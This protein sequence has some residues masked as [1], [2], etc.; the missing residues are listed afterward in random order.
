MD[1][2]AVVTR[3]VEVI[4]NTGQLVKV[5]TSD[6]NAMFMPRQPRCVNNLV[7]PLML[8]DDVF[9][10]VSNRFECMRRHM[11]EYGFMDTADMSGFIKVVRKN[12][13]TIGDEDST[14]ERELDD[15]NGQGDLLP[16]EERCLYER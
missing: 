5:T 2:K 6:I 14:V 7:K 9:D 16:N 12:L 13:I 15:D 4:P 10:K 8:S 3:E 11:S 1:Y